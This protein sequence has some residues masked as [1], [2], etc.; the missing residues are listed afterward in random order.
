M[1]LRWLLRDGQEV[2]LTKT[3]QCLVAGWEGDLYPAHSSSCR[4]LA[5]RCMTTNK[6]DQ[7][8]NSASLES[9]RDAGLSIRAELSTLRSTV[10][11]HA[12]SSGKAA[13][14]RHEWF[15][16]EPQLTLRRSQPLE[17][18]FQA[19]LEK[20]PKRRNDW[21]MRFRLS[22][23]SGIELTPSSSRTPAGVGGVL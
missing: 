14:T 16:P 6:I 8:R 19:R 4:H 11:L 12:G 17:A 22:M 1:V 3:W 15:S 18:G 10:R 20:G 13:K 5:P 21:P 9:W 7:F 23:N 2:N